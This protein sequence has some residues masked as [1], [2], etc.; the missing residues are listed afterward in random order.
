LLPF[1]AAS[2]EH[3]PA[4]TEH[5]AVK[6]EHASAKAERTLGPKDVLWRL[7]QRN[8]SF[9]AGHLSSEGSTPAKRTALV[10]GQHPHAVILTCADS[11]VPPEVI[12]NEGLGR[13]FVVRVAGVVA[14]PVVVASVEYAA[15]HLHAPLIV[16]MGHTRCGAVKAAIDTPSPVPADSPEAN[17]ESILERLRPGIPKLDAA[18]DIWKAAVYG[19]V[20]RSVEDLLHTSKM[21]PEMGKAGHIG[22][23]GAVYELETGRVVFSNMV[24]FEGPEAVTHNGNL[25]EWQQTPQVARAH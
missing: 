13:L 11:R 22:V 12:F 2:S 7:R 17:I 25:L 24:S 6:T 18:A 19:G 10:A 20:E 21:L 5:E 16:V 1:V 9:V 4:K 3:A 15:E 8:K 23:V 14:D